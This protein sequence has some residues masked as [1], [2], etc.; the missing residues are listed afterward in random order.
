MV[1]IK[2]PKSFSSD[3]DWPKNVDKNFKHEI[4]SL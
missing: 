1:V 4:N 3:F 2:E